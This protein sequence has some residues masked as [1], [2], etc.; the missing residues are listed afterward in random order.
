MILYIYLNEQMYL[1]KVALALLVPQGNDAV[2]FA[3]EFG[4]FIFFQWQ[5]P[6]FQPGLAL[7]VLDQDES[8]L[9]S[10]VIEVKVERDE[11]EK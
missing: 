11:G 4:F 10:K 8:D 2:N 7:S 6:F 9:Y 1:D 5:K 3:L